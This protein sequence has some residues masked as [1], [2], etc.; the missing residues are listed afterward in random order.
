MSAL[1][2]QPRGGAL[3]RLFSGRVRLAY[4]VAVALF[5]GS[6]AQFHHRDTGFSSLISIG[7][8]LDGTKV[9]ALRTVPHFVYQGSAGY[10][11]AYYVQLALHPTL[12][13]PEL[14]KAID[15]LPYRAKR[16]LFCWSAWALGLG[17]PEW[18]VQAHALLNVFC[19]LAL[20][21]LLLRWFPPDHWEN[22]VRWAAVLFSHGLIMSVR[23][24]LVDGPSLLL[25]ALALRWLETGRGVA[26][27]VTLALAGLGKETNLLAS[28]AVPVQWNAPRTWLRPAATVAL[29]ALPLLLWMG[30]VRWKF[31]PA[32]DPGLGN[33]TLP[34]AGYAEKFMATVRDV[35]SPSAGSVHW[36]TFA[37]LVAL[38]VQWVFFVVVRRPGDR[39]WRV[40]AAFALMMAFL[41][42]PV[43]EG[44]PGAATRVLLPM[45]LAFNLLLPRG[46]R[47]LPVLLA[48]NLTVVASIHEFSP[49]H[50]FYTVRGEPTAE[51]ALRVTTGPG[52][53]G[54][55]HEGSNRWRWSG[56][57]AEL[58]L[59]N[60]GA[61]HLRVVVQGRVSAAVNDRKISVSRGEG[62]LWADEVG[63]RHATL[64]LGFDLPPGETTL[65]F[66]TDQP[67]EKV[68]TDPRALAYCVT[69]L[70]IVVTAVAR[71][72]SSP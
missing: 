60:T 20:A 61:G 7:D 52:W 42:T 43:W 53:H 63:P 30:Y 11:G 46:V 41:A 16:I 8:I 23:H 28:A 70:E 21:W 71:P 40:G 35:I 67:A 3:L 18:I 13:N 29:I 65:V 12:D 39:W 69:N 5:L 24:S 56:G 9:T 54:A 49:P 19:W 22:F 6:V 27:V 32:E 25:V 15:N 64:A 62:L 50:D 59:A 1:Q 17:Q 51:A 57:R 38:S 14:T 55:E 4:V 34:L 48:G 44:Y 10:D 26:G 37:A 31:G 45:T 33:F 68:G 2:P 66:S 58:R 72:R 47:W 36:A